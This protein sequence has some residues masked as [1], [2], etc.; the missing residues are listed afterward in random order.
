MTDNDIIPVRRAAL[1][2]LLKQ[3]E[4]RTDA[5]TLIRSMLDNDGD[6]PGITYAADYKHPFA[7]NY[8]CGTCGMG[9]DDPI[10]VFPA[11]ELRVQE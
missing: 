3:L 11:R 8:R 7:I 4:P 2:N 10:H 1:D 9:L 5:A 6:T